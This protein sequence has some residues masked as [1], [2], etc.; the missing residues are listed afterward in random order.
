V[1]RR[2]R[3]FGEVEDDIKTYCCMLWTRLLTPDVLKR[4]HDVV[5]LVL[6]SGGGLKETLRGLLVAKGVFVEESRKQRR[7]VSFSRSGWWL[8]SPDDTPGLD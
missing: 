1:K 8:R 3:S 6:K 4:S 5:M 7:R 2:A